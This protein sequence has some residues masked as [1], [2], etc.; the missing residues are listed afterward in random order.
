MKG[1]HCAL[2]LSLPLPSPSPSPSPFPNPSNHL[3][4]LHLHLHLHVRVHLRLRLHL[5]LH[6]HLHLRPFLSVHPFLLISFSLFL[7]LSFSPSLLL[8]Q[9]LQPVEREL[10]ALTFYIACTGERLS[11]FKFHWPPVGGIHNLCTDQGDPEQKPGSTLGSTIEEQ[12]V[13]QVDTPLSDKSLALR[14]G[15]SP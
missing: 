4:P 8:P 12:G 14:Q 2:T 13:L 11:R 7:F 9:N 15:V 6:K 5:H 3:R 1:G 10:A